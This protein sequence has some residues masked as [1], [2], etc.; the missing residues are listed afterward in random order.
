LAALSKSTDFDWR[1]ASY[2]IAGSRA[3]AHA[4]AAADLL[5]QS[6]LHDLLVALDE[7]DEEV[8]TKRFG[9]SP[10]DEDV[11]SALERRL[12]EVAGAALGGKLR[13]GRSRNDQIATLIR[14]YL[15]DQARVLVSG[16]LEVAEALMDQAARHDQ[17]AMPGK[18]HLQYAQPVLLSHHLLAHVWPLLRDVERLEQWGLRAAASPYGAGALAGS[19]LGLDPELVAGQLGLAGTCENSIDATAARDQVAEFAFICAL[20]GVNLSRLAEEVIIW[21]TPEFGYVELDD[22]WS[23]GSSIMPQKKNPDIA[24]LARGKAGRL[25]GNLAGLLATLKGL[26]LAYNRDLQEDKEPVFDAVD[27]LGRL[28][29]AVAGLVGSLKFNTSRLEQLAPSGYAL[30]TD[31]AERLVKSGLPFRQAHELTGRLV[32]LA[33]SCGKELSQLT[34]SELAQVDPALSPDVLSRLT[35][36]EALASR[37]GAGGTAPIRVKEQL[38]AARSQIAAARSH[39]Q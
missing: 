1:L 38:Q 14:L 29:P 35:L 27:T 25:I 12:V 17:V 8:R 24:E 21:S 3:H 18:T 20:I 36:E 23:T 39:Q 7:V 28:L 37:D 31:V 6:E 2:D 10:G 11:H 26:P 22:A 30:A 16:V 9:P 4:L 32:R 19:T 5:S 15:R 33:E 13:A 34:A